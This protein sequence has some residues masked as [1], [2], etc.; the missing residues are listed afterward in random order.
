MPSVN[1]NQIAN[2]Y[3]K[4]S[5]SRSENVL[6]SNRNSKISFGGGSAANSFMR[7]SARKS[8][9]SSCDS[10]EMVWQVPDV[11]ACLES[12]GASMTNDTPYEVLNFADGSFERVSIL[13][14]ASHHQFD[15]RSFFQPLSEISLDDGNGYGGGMAN[16]INSTTNTLSRFHRSMSMVQG[17]PSQNLHS[18]FYPDTLNDQISKVVLRRRNNS[19]C[20]SGSIMTSCPF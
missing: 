11:F 7:N 4:P 18:K 1:E 17:W 9:L 19:T 6:Q 8:D 20:E 13:G 14:S 16:S 2:D 5:T 3:S 15:H 12:L 10:S